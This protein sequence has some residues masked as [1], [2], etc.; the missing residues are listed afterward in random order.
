ME[1]TPIQNS[2][3]EYPGN[4]VVMA[5]PGSG[6]TYVISEKIKKILGDDGMLPF[7]GVIAISYTRKASENLKQ[8]ALVDGVWSKNSFFGTIDSFCLTQIVL[9]FANFVMGYSFVEAVPVAYSDLSE[10]QK[11]NFKWLSEGHPSY[12]DIPQA[13]WRFFYSL[14]REGKVMIESLELLAMHVLKE[15]EACKRYMKA[16]YKYIFIDEYQDA[17]EYTNGV[18][19]ELLSLGIV[20]NVVGDTNQ[21]IFGFAHKSS[22]Y[23]KA[24]EQSA[25]FKAFRLAR[26]F[27]CSAPIINYSNRLIDKESALIETNEDGVELIEVTGAED[28]V[29]AYIAEYLEVD[30]EKYAVVDKSEVAILVKNKRTQDLIDRNIEVPHRVIESTN[31]DADMNPRSRLYGLLLQL[32]FDAEMRFMKVTDEFFDYDALAE[33]D[34]KKLKQ[35]EGEIRSV[36]RED[37]EEELPRLFK[38]VG[39]VLLPEFDEG[40]SIAHLEEVLADEKMLDTYR[41]ITGDEVLIMTLHKAKGLEFDLVYHLNL[42][43]WELPIRK[44]VNNDWDNPQY[45]TWGQDLDLHYVGVTRARKACFLITSTLRHNGEGAV[46]NSCPSEFLEWNGVKMLRKDYTYGKE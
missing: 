42:N 7:Q 4:T 2:I 45:P 14:Y 5:S 29:A 10:E 1:A 18:L 40:S 33:S 13:T 21:S 30:C 16:R 23:L 12:A 8:R 37:V 35:L 44:I 6:K 25:E 19:M 22:I 36:N 28:R 11:S 24:I 27:R 39:D 17:D 38:A 9:P 34:R 3:I 31:L 26:N 20:G 46:K 43:Q 32:Y 15:C 41:P